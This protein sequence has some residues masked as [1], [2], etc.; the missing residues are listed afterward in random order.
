MY[1]L[2]EI[3]IQLR[4]TIDQSNA[5]QDLHW[6]SQFRGVGMMMAW[7]TFEV[8]CTLLLVLVHALLNDWIFELLDH[9]GQ[10]NKGASGK[11]SKIMHLGYESLYVVIKA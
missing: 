11:Q 3:Y 6:W 8:S 7:P 2:P 9:D 4:H 10:I 1:R 5:D